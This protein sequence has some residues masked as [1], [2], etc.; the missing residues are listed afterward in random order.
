MGRFL[1]VIDIM[2]VFILCL[3]VAAVNAGVPSCET[4]WEEKCWDEPTQKCHSVQ[5]PFTT[6]YYEQECHSV[7]V[8]KV[9]KCNQV[10]RQKTEYKS[11]QECNTVYEKQCNKVSRKDCNYH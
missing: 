1:L 5:K 3:A 4:V 7:Q 8:P 10:P 11:E 6:T 9:E 2:K